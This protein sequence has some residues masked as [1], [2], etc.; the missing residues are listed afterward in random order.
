MLWL[1]EWSPL[2]VLNAGRPAVVF[3]FVLSSTLH[4]PLEIRYDKPL[5]C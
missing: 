2:R 4:M 1:L 5:I 3:F